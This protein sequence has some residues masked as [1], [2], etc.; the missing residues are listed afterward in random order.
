MSIG[1]HLWC[2]PPL[3]GLAMC[4]SI[5]VDLSTGFMALWTLLEISGLNA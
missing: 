5:G 1:G 2:S 4:F 3:E